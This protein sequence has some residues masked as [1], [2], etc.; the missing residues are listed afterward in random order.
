MTERT[1]HDLRAQWPDLSKDQ[2]AM[3]LAKIA[4][5][6][7]DMTPDEQAVRLGELVRRAKDINDVL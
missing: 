6:W 7:N 4:L 5:G 3:E 2:R 1:N